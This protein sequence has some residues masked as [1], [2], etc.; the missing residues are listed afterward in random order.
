MFASVLSAAILGIEV[1]PVQV[2]ADVSNGLP[3]FTMVGFPSAQVKE[4]QD[5]VRT[6]LK[7]NGFQFPPKKITVN[8]APADMKKEGAGFDMP[9]AAAVMAAF[10][11]IKPQV[12]EGV[13]MSGEISLNGEIHEVSGIL[14]M[15]LCARDLGCRLCVVP[16]GNLKE[17]RLIRDVPVAGVKNLQEL[18]QCLNDPEPYIQREKQEEPEDGGKR[19]QLDFADIEGQE[20]AKRAAEIAVSGFHNILF[21]G[22]PGTGKTML[23]RRLPTIMPGISFEEKLELT[24]IYSIAGLLAREHPLISQRPFRSPH[25]T[26]TAYALAGGGRN[27]VRLRW[28]TGVCCFWMRCLSFPEVVWNFSGSRWRIR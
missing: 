17:G 9:V 22:P 26:S 27:P 10:E 18:M 23:A 14:P 7:N 2:E 1:R 3:S 8:L 12:L 19:N 16:Y 4:A 21:I 28:P 6:A 25:H 24:K 15:V 5:R 13:M 20:S 11:M